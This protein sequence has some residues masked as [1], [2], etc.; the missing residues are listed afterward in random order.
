MSKIAS[1]DEETSALV[2][3]PPHRRTTLA[4]PALFFSRAALRGCV[5][6]DPEKVHARLLLARLCRLDPFFF[7]VILAFAVATVAPFSGIAE[8]VSRSSFSTALLRRGAAQA[9][10]FL[11]RA[12]F[13]FWRTRRRSV[14]SRVRRVVV[15][16]LASMVS[17]GTPASLSL[18][19]SF[20]QSNSACL[21]V[22]A[23]K[24]NV[25]AAIV[26]RPLLGVSYLFF[27]S[28]FF[29]FFVRTVRF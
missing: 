28:F 26:L 25:R 13:I 14:L 2:S 4:L 20:G 18:L 11:A 22:A 29:L 6:V 27:F 10:T 21:A 1:R 7:F 12:F 8:E 17:H 16:P 19:V 24:V 15:R 3:R 23:A 9:M 5:L